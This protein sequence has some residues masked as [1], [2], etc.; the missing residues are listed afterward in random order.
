[1]NYDNLSLLS[2]YNTVPKELI[3]YGYIQLENVQIILKI[4]T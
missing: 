4:I 1:M 3:I 2:I